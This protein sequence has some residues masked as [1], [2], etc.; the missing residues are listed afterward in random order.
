MS[1]RSRIAPL[2]LAVALAVALAP[3]PATPAAG[4]DAQASAAAPSGQAEAEPSPAALADEAARLY[5]EGSYEAA[6]PLLERADAAGALD[7]PGLYR[8]F[9]T[10][11]VAGDAR[12][13]DTLQRALETLEREVAAGD[14]LESAFYLAN[15]QSNLGKLSAAQE[16]AAAAVARVE[17]GDWATPA[18]GAG[19]FRLG[20]LYEDAG[21]GEQAAAWY[22]K[23]VETFAAA[24]AADGSARAYARWA[25]RALADRAKEAGDLQA[26]AD[27]RKAMLAD[28]AGTQEQF[29]ELAVLMA[30][31]RRWDDAAEAWRVALLRRPAT[32][33]RARYAQRLA[34]TAN[35]LGGLPEQAP[36]GRPWSAYA[37]AELESFML[38]RAQ[39]LRAIQAEIAEAVPT[40][41]PDVDAFRERLQALRPAF[42]AAAMEYLLRGGP[43]RETAFRS[44]YAPLIFKDAEWNVPYAAPDRSGERQ[45][46]APGQRPAGQAERGRR[47]APDK[48]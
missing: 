8:L 46:V 34:L 16:T 12:A 38:E 5:A 44:G 37:P 14:A 4:P 33:N 28:G 29:D 41:Q 35:E 17:S 47:N 27:H 9:Y 18:D 40:R 2:P 3:A 15:A 21:N 45:R 26:E 22:A 25:H 10:R 48:N 42:V 43:L 19:R 24:D 36:D 23:A 32:G 20:K 13:R 1:P 39:A 31:L 11:N 6:R 7:G 30:K